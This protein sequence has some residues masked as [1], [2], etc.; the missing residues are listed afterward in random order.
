MPINLTPLRNKQRIIITGNHGVQKIYDL[1][2]HVLNHI[3]KPFDFIDEND[4]K[5]TDAPI[6]ILKGGAHLENGSAAFHQ[7]EPHMMLIHKISK[8]IPEGYD[9]FEQYVSQIEGLANRLPKAG[10]IVYNESDNMAMIIGKNEREDVKPLEY[11]SI[12]GK[13]SANG[14]IIEHENDKK[15]IITDNENFLSH[16]AAAKTLLKRLGATES[17]F[18]NALKAL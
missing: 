5:L 17:Q 13:A 16:A 7:F 8:K 4:Q 9:S 18:F 12:E 11:S 2:T 1:V 15:E 3:N 14:F 6:V 10:A